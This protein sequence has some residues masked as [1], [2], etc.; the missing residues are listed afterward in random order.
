VVKK[1]GY[2]HSLYPRYPG[3]EDEVRRFLASHAAR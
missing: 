3:F 2:G 1:L